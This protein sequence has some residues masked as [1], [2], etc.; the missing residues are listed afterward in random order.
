MLA[1]SQNVAEGIMAGNLAGM[2]C[3]PKLTAAAM[4][5]VTLGTR[6]YRE[7]REL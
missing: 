2:N 1:H 5:V 3:L 4:T 6:S 7:D